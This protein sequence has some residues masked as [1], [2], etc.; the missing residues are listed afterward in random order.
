M[1]KSNVRARVLKDQTSKSMTSTLSRCY[2]ENLL[3]P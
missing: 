2:G 3:P 1:D